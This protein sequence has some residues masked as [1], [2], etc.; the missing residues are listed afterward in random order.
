MFL[1]Q[2]N[3]ASDTDQATMNPSKDFFSSGLLVPLA[4][5]AVVLLYRTRTSSALQ[6]MAIPN[7]ALD[8]SSELRM[9]PCSHIQGG[10]PGI[11]NAPVSERA[12]CRG[13]G[14]VQ[15]QWGLFD[16]TKQLS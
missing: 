14:Q 9:Q 13:L 4:I 6:V 10:L 8:C 7:P 16:A 12:R 15:E 11:R 5:L 3:T 1:I 2:Q